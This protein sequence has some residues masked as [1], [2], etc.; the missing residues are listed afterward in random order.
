MVG[1]FA[2]VAV[3][4]VVAQSTNGGGWRASFAAAN[5]DVTSTGTPAAI[6]LPEHTIPP[7]EKHPITDGMPE[8]GQVVVGVKRMNVG[9]QNNAENS[10]GCIRTFDVRGSFTGI[11]KLLERNAECVKYADAVR[12][13]GS[14]S[15]TIV[16]KGAEYA[17]TPAAT[18]RPNSRAN[19]DAG[20]GKAGI[21]NHTHHHN[22]NNHNNHAMFISRWGGSSVYH[23]LFDTL[24]PAWILCHEAKVFGADGASPRPVQVYVLDE[25]GFTVK[26][27]TLDHLERILFG[28]PFIQLHQPITITSDH[29]VV[30]GW[31]DMHLYHWGMGSRDQYGFVW[32]DEIA[33]WMIKLRQKILG[34]IEEL[35]HNDPSCGSHGRGRGRGAGASVAVGKTAV[36]WMRRAGARKGE[37]GP[38]RVDNGEPGIRW[39]IEGI[40]AAITLLRANGYAVE[41]VAMGDLTFAKLATMLSCPKILIGIEGAAFANTLLMKAGGIVQLTFLNPARSALF[42]GTRNVVIGFHSS[43]VQYFRGVQDTQFYMYGNT[44]HAKQLLTVVNDMEERLQQQL[45]TPARDQAYSYRQYFGPA[46]SST[47]QDNGVVIE[48]WPE[49]IPD[50]WK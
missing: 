24:L 45:R 8:F 30:G 39:D 19:K 23:R 43:A 14:D 38:D 2:V 27:G 44:L 28:L 5:T 35:G 7:V 33:P 46:P 34:K 31:G 10:L 21:I 50:R 37:A 9:T 49:E 41:E 40:D 36:I 1:G 15:Y 16:A 3:L 12:V 11:A 18:L 17:V 47:V 20:K 48:Q 26:P 25:G 29:A 32:R 4:L 42:N 22:H 6:Q 13:P